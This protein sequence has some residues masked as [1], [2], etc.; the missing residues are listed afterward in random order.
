MFM[1]WIWVGF[2]GPRQRFLS[3]NSD[4]LDKMHVQIL[5]DNWKYKNILIIAKRMM[6]TNYLLSSHLFIR[7][8][9]MLKNSLQIIFQV[10]A[11]IRL[12]LAVNI[13]NENEPNCGKMYQNHLSYFSFGQNL[14]Y[15]STRGPSTVLNVSMDS[16][17]ILLYTFIQLHI[18]ERV[19]LLGILHLFI[20][21]E[22]LKSN[23]LGQK[24]EAYQLT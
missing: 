9:K 7:N 21:N 23:S 6:K 10:C 19:H 11:N 18:F 3:H 16:S 15:T 24:K 17:K 5:K 14:K 4:H 22:I 2:D 1:V 13:G 20:E 12:Y 8:P